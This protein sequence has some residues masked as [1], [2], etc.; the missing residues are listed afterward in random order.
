MLAEPDPRETDGLASD[1]FTFTGTQDGRI[2]MQA[3]MRRLRPLLARLPVALLAL[4]MAGGAVAQAPEKAP[5]KTSFST[6][7]TDIWWNKLKSGNGTQMIQTGSFIFVTVYVF[8]LDRT[9]T[10]F[11]G[12]LNASA[13]NVFTGP[14]FVSTGPPFNGPFDPMTVVTRQAGTMTFQ[15]LSVDTGM[16]SYTVDGVAVSEPMERQPLTPDNYNGTFASVATQTTTNCANAADNGTVT[17]T[18]II[19]ITQTGSQGESMTIAQQ[20]PGGISCSMSGTYSQL[21]RSGTFGKR[22]DGT[23][24]TYNCTTGEVGLV[25]WI[26]MNN[27]VNQ[28]NARTFFQSTNMG[29]QRVGRITGVIPNPN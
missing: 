8:G 18:Q 6:D 25:Q 19:Q 26:E 1:S 29:C 9:A 23:F 15:A 20:L 16:L 4:A 27:H 7:F 14:L 13:A 12:E 24:D 11:T 3:M 2:D 22:P 5:F 21:G 17:N 28:F 10:W